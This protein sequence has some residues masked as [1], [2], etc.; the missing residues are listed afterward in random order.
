MDAKFNKADA[1]VRY[2]LFKCYCVSFFM[3][4]NYGT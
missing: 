3:D 1:L 2:K 4:A